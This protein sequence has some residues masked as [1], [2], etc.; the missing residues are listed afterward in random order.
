MVHPRDPPWG[1]AI[2]MPEAASRRSAVPADGCGEALAGGNGEAFG[3]DQGKS[4]H[5]R[6]RAVY[7][8]G[9]II[10]SRAT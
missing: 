7:A 10:A 1:R 5:D 8:A 3:R 9:S 4:C 2:E 6:R